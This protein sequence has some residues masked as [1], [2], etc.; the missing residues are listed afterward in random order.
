MLRPGM[1]IADTYLV[2]EE[3]GSGGMSKVYLAQNI[4]LKKMRA[5][6]ELNKEDLGSYDSRH[7][8]LMKRQ[9]AREALLLKKL[10][11]P[12]LPEIIDIVGSPEQ[13]IIVMEYIEG[14]TLE[15]L[16]R[17]RGRL[18][19]EEVV[20]Y[21]AELCRILLYLHRNDPP[22]IYRDIKPSNIMVKGDGSLILIDFGTARE[23]EQT[24]TG[25]D[26]VCLGTRGYAA[27]EQYGG[28]GQTDER[29]DIY[30]IGMTMGYLL[31]GQSPDQP[32]YTFFPLR[33]W[34][35]EVSQGMEEIVTVCVRDDPKERFPDCR[36][37]LEAL[38]DREK[39]SRNY[40]RKEKRKLAAFSV[41]VAASLLLTL[42]GLCFRGFRQGWKE[43]T[44]D[45]YFA[46]ARN[47]GREEEREAWLSLALKLDPG[48][49]R[50][51]Q[52]ILKQY[53]P[54]NH[55]SMDKAARIQ[56]LVS[57]VVKGR[58]AIN[59]LERQDQKACAR[60]CYGL[61]TAYFYDMGG[62][63]GKK[64]SEQW[65]EAALKT[66]V[67]HYKEYDRDRAG[68]YRK[69]GAYYNGFLAAGADR[70]GAEADSYQEFYETLS[71]LND[72]AGDLQEKVE[73]KQGG[74]QDAA[75]VYLITRELVT[76]L[77]EFGRDIA[78]NTD[79]SYIEMKKMLEDGNNRSRIHFLQKYKSK[80]EMEQLQQMLRGLNEKML[81]LEQMDS[82]GEDNE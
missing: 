76:E 50:T 20:K 32:P 1:L 7:Y 3:I 14:V 27:P 34:N 8:E 48:N 73:N 13:M 53:V 78:E 23:Y 15:E 70:S 43:K 18:T 9:L 67:D 71:R 36:A 16:V 41:L 45:T 28:A 80:E 25:G 60:F 29:T 39:C 6:K 11:H 74:R 31:T 4:R 12:G 2:I 24:E 40:K 42:A 46:C 22:I 35:P 57:M 19:E 44:L 63:T 37:L 58:S 52:E 68:V 54:R 10:D 49:G 82:R 5:L 75:A 59:Y 30:G 51:Y 65:F 21:C 38:T 79:I 55:F 17:D 64:E 72:L 69:I 81:L 26:T 77:E 61:A 66:S 33:Q 62:W 56:K 47:A